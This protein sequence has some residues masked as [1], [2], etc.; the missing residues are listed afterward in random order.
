MQ[1]FV[2]FFSRTHST[3]T[4]PRQGINPCHSC[5]LHHSCSNTGSLTH[6][7][8]PGIEPMPSQ[9]QCQILN[10]LHHSRNYCP[11]F[12][13][14]RAL[15]KMIMSYDFTS[16]ISAIMQRLPFSASAFLRETQRIMQQA[17]ENKQFDNFSQYFILYNLLDLSSKDS[18]LQSLFKTFILVLLETIFF[19][20]ILISTLYKMFKLGN[21][22][23]S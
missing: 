23:L 4:F 12:H 20:Q 3:W 14:L 13:W 15:L 19:F 21:C 7:A 22:T 9:R 16:Y 17:G 2:F 10:P 18:L 6:C 11:M 8:G 5:N 1:K